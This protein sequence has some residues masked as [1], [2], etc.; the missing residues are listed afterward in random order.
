EFVHKARRPRSLPRLRGRARRE[1]PRTHMQAAPAHLSALH[2]PVT[3]PA[4]IPKLLSIPAIAR[5]LCRE[6]GG[7][8]LTL[9][10]VNLFARSSD[11]TSERGA[12]E[13]NFHPHPLPSRADRDPGSRP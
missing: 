8:P 2:V 11:L 12:R 3:F 1:K 9:F 5:H 4:S 7:E 10:V 6:T 13:P